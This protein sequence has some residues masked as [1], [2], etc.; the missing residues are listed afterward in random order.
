MRELIVIS[1]P[2]N[3]GKYPQAKTLLSED[4]D[5]VL[6][7]RDTIRA[8]LCA[9]MDEW[10]ITLIMRAIAIRL[11]HFEHEYSP[12]VCAWNHLPDDRQLWDQLAAATHVPLRWLDTRNPDVQAMIPPLEADSAAQTIS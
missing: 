8:A 11:L 2:A 7:H 6:V 1:G 12:V 4:P 10:E 3:S 9:T 5:R